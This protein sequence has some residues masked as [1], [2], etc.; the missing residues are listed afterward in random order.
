[1]KARQSLANNVFRVEG[2]GLHRFFMEQST[3]TG[4]DIP[5]CHKIYQIARKYTKLPQNT[6][7]FE[8]WD[9]SSRKKIVLGNIIFY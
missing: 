1:L 6:P 7:N 8:L 2:S 4:N 9:F 3:K 5:N